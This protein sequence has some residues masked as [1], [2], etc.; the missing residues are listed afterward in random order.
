[1]CALVTGV[2]TCALPI[3]P[4]GRGKKCFFQKHDAGSFGK[5]VRHVDIAEKDGS[6]EPYLYVENGDGLVQCVKMGTIEFYGW[7]SSVATEWKRVV[8][9]K[10]VSVR[11][12][13]GCSRSIKKEK[14]SREMCMVTV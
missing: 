8:Q 7:A 14:R 12:D 10:S 5:H 3:C 4:Q 9:G 13:L 1:M 11:G 2:Q 6:V